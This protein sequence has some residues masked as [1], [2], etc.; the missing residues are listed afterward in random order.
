MPW[1][2]ADDVRRRV[3]TIA[4]RLPEPLR[5]LATLALNYRWSWTGGDELFA[6]VD[7][8]GFEL[9]ANNP[10]RLLTGASLEAL[11]RAA[12]E[13]A[14]TERIA[15]AAAD[16]D[17]HLAAGP[18][19]RTDPVAFVCA[20]F[21]V[22][23]SL[24]LYSGGLGVLAGDVLKEASDQGVPLVGVGLLYR[25]G[26]FR[27][28][29][30]RGGWQNEWWDEV[31]PERLPMVLVS[32]DDGSVLTVSVPV[33]GAMV[34]AQV[35]RVDVGRVPLYLLD[36]ERPE[37]PRTLRWITSRLYIA[38]RATRLAQYALLGRGGMI[39]LREMGITPATVHLNEGHAALAPLELTRELVAGG[40]RA[41]AALRAARARTVFTTHTPVA[42]GNES[43]D[44]A[45]L[46]EVVG[47]LPGQLGLSTSRF[48][49]LGRVHPADKAEAF[50]LTPLGIHSSRATNGVSR[51]HGI[52][53]RGMWRDI[54]PKATRDDD[55]PISHVTNGVHL[56]TWMGPPMAALLDRHLP[57]GWRARADDAAVWAAVDSIPD[58]ELWALRGRL[59]AGLV[60]WVKDR[61]LRDRL[62][63]SEPLGYATAAARGFRDDVLTIG[64]ARRLATY[65]RLSLLVYDPPRALRLLSGDRPVQ[66]IISGKAHP[67]DDAGKAMLKSLFSL[68]GETGAGARVVFVE[69][70]D[71]GVS[72]QIVA[73]CD[74]WINVP[75]F[76]L[77]ACGTSGMKAALNGGLNVSVLDGWWEEA[78]DGTNGWGFD[79]TLEG[80]DE[81]D[82]REL[83]R[84]LE[85]EV[86]PLFHRRDASGVPAG[87]VERI[88]ASLRTNGPRFCAS[89]MV[90]E[91]EERIWHTTGG[92]D[93]G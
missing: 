45:T 38:D 2:G 69:D 89:R 22:H 36:A 75:R 78:C 59:R 92:A 64:F 29:V 15:A 56:P 28:R 21:A 39:A 18:D 30:D 34:T 50:G 81:A 66:L 93:G 52:V 13:G 62:A 72:A 85:D 33:G 54:F 17:G 73:G 20:E 31:E 74:V 41:D 14:L 23:R 51:R 35:W 40:M 70:Y 46:L 6:A 58:A 5:G 16:L 77:E 7:A 10:V 32:R 71:M 68:R 63:R 67:Q 82:A 43:I 27:Q 12:A 84:I 86:V 19:G 8:H 60:A 61:S 88:R 80:S 57:P 55:V 25:Q 4:S 3:D 53:A 79:G 90:R 1:P 49:G 91:Y 47:D 44:P 26:Y 24:P 65:K 48:I 87:W 9:G 11:G 83:F 37:N 76:P 42:A